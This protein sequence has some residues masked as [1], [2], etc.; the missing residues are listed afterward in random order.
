[1]EMQSV[2]HGI[3]PPKLSLSAHRLL[4]RNLVLAS[5]VRLKDQALQLGSAQKLYMQSGL[6]GGL[7]GLS[8]PMLKRVVVMSGSASNSSGETDLKPLDREVYGVPATVNNDGVEPFSG[9]SGS[10]SFCGLTHQSIEEGGLMSAPF[11]VDK[12]SF[13]WLLGP[14]ALI[15]SLIVPQFF[16]GQTIE[17]FLKDTIF[18]EIVTSLSF[19]AMF[20]VGLAT[21]LLVTDQIQRPYL[22]FSPK[23]WSLITGLRGY[24]TSAFFA[25]G[26]KVIVPL[27]VVYVTWPMLGLPALVAVV[28]FLVGCISQRAFEAYVDKRGS[29]C[30]P[31]VPIIFEVYRIYQ[32]TKAAF[33]I[34]K[35]MFNLR[36]LPES[37][38]LMERQSALFA[39]IVTFQVLGVVCL[40]SLLTFLLRLF[41]SRPVAENY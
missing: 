34:E 28:P 16:L 38:Q 21:F 37:A 25:M 20:Y 39:M 17:A 3:P 26:F 18:T 5:H 13:L 2:F 27:F 1:M 19:E 14:V 30:W 8:M 36:S 11:N 41:P 7:R 40:W 9:K 31:L 23:R 12:S 6:K 29:S 10:V 24:L 15:S 33:F 35:L 22:Q 4:S 32:L